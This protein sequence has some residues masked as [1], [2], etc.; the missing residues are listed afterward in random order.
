M[1]AALLGPL[2]QMMHPPGPRSRRDR[3]FFS[4]LAPALHLPL[5]LS[6]PSLGSIIFSS[7]KLMDRGLCGPFQP[8]IPRCPCSVPCWKWNSII[9]SLGKRGP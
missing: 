4:S 6:C 8:S 1:A 5:A 7:Y 9:K 2:R 3:L